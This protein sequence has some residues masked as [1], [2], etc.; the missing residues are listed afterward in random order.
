MVAIERVARV[1]NPRFITTWCLPSEAIDSAELELPARIGAARRLA[2]ID[3]ADDAGVAV[4]RVVLVV[5]QVE[6]VGTYLDAVLPGQVEG[7]R[8]REIR[9]T[10]GGAARRV[11]ALGRGH[12]AGPLRG[13][14]DLRRAG[15]V[16]GIADGVGI[17]ALRV[18]DG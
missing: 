10:D 16:R 9:V 13:A 1:T 7:A 15:Q 11:P 4:R 18:H 8:Q 3:V 5:E 17:A 6:D 12:V 2:V 14:E